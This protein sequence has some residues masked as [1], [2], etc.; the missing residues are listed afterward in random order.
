MNAG[1]P[2]DR[3]DYI[4][5][6]WL[7]TRSIKK[8]TDC[9]FD[10]E[11][12]KLVDWRRVTVTKEKLFARLRQS[13]VPGSELPFLR[14]TVRRS[15]MKAGV[16]EDRVDYIVDKW[17]KTTSDVCNKHM[18][19]NMRSGCYA[20]QKG[21][22]KRVK[23]CL[24]CGGQ[25]VK[26]AP[27]HGAEDCGHNPNFMKCHEACMGKG[28]DGTCDGQVPAAKKPHCEACQRFYPGEVQT[29]MACGGKC[30]RVAP[31]T[32]VEDCMKNPK[33]AKCHE[34]CMKGDGGNK[35]HAFYPGREVQCKAC[36]KKCWDMKHCTGPCDSDPT[37]VACHMKCMQ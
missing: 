24:E 34:S 15:L 9:Y 5:D 35:C 8:E 7:R 23:E 1:V 29:C 11:C 17:L 6:K 3:V 13:S 10:L 32:S 31:C 37:F 33:L 19:K 28:K 12:S 16:P 18:D 27:C 20:C 26:T 2:E 22:P 36:G 30:M 25:C 21:Y 4:V 14:R